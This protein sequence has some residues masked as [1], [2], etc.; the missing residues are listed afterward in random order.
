MPAG[1]QC[2]AAAKDAESAGR[3][4]GALGGR[5]VGFDE[6]AG[7]ESLGV[8]AEE[9]GVV[10]DG[11]AGHLDDGVFG[12]EV[13]VGDEGVSE[14]FA[15]GGVGGIET[16]G[17]LVD[18]DEEGALGAE[19]GDVDAVGGRIGVGGCEGGGGDHGCDLGA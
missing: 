7:I 11:G 14:D 15:D 2:R 1:T 6:T 18:G 19:F 9:G 13:C 12:E 16:H 3:P 5:G 4:F 17:F 10:V 8:G